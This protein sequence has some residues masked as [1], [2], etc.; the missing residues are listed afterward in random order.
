RLKLYFMIGL[1]T[2]EDEDVRAI[3]ETGQRM[4]LIG[5]RLVGRKAEVTV[6]ASSHVPKPHT[7]FQ[8]CAQDSVDEIRRKQGLLRSVVSERGLKLKYHD[9]GGSLLEGVLSR[10]D[11]RLAD[12]IELAWQRGARFDSW[13]E[14]FDIDDWLAVLDE[15]G[16]D[17]P[18]YLGTRPV[19]ARLPW[20][21]IDVGLE[22]GFL[23]AEYRKALKSRLSPPCGKVV[24]QL[25][26]HSNLDD[27]RADSRRLVCYDCGVACDLSKMRGERLDYLVQL[28]AEHRRERPSP[29]ERSA[30]DGGAPATVPAPPRPSRRGKNGG[31]RQRKPQ[32]SFP[33]R[34]STRYRLRYTKLGR[35]AY[36]GHLDTARMLMRLF[37]RAGIQ[38][39]YSRGFHPKPIMQF[40]PALPLGVAS[41]GEMLDVAIE[42]PTPGSGAPLP[43]DELRQRLSQLSPEGVEFTGAWTLPPQNSPGLTKL[44]DAYHLLITPAPDGMTF[45]AA[46][47]GRIAARFLARDEVQV[48]RKDRPIDVRA[49]VEGIEVIG[50][51]V[52]ARLIRA[53]DWPE[54]PALFQ[55]RVAMSPSGSVK[56]IE[57]A[58]G[59]GVYGPDDP[60]ATHAFMAR[61]GF[62]GLGRY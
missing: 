9:C 2:E 50:E 1:P 7:P 40:S 25:V 54:A 61:L 29:S 38:T 30:A 24:G 41:F 11:R 16:V 26:H 21:H 14:L 31:R 53:L 12:A 46:R 49:F 19:T 33:E 10:G 35:A 55:V 58:R 37:R 13:D 60:R 44:I 17:R 28:G 47:L 4:L 42:D 52:A 23:L 32:V 6:S 22:D 51:S 34:P 48:M 39:A 18:S 20:D 43:A 45:D 62:S 15:C 36:L 59:L 27:A 56:P 57:V 8:W 5:R 3:V